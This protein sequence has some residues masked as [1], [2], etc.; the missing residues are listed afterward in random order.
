MYFFKEIS[1]HKN[2]LIKY[3]I[4]YYIVA[5]IFK[6]I[7]FF[8]STDFDIYKLSNYFGREQIFLTIL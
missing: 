8:E 1:K 7:T 4:S 6:V 2:L 5:I 3:Y